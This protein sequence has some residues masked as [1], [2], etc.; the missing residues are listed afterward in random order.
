MQFNPWVSICKFIFCKTIQPR[1]LE[2]AVTQ[3]SYMEIEIAEQLRRSGCKL[4][5]VTQFC[6][7]TFGMGMRLPKFYC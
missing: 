6:N 5:V 7:I 1:T 2:N 4:Y 3:L